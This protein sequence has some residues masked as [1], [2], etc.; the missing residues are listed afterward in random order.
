VDFDK[1]TWKDD[2]AAFRAICHKLN[3]P[4]AVERSRSGKGAHIRIFFEQPVA[5]GTARCLGSLPLTRTMER[6]DQLGLD[7]Y[8]RPFLPELG[9][10]AQ[11][12]LWQPDRT[13]ASKES[14]KVRLY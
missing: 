12:R 6:R 10:D 2:T 1:K 3:V 7:S 14:T 4:A 13:P 9:H 11:R 8:D 5:A